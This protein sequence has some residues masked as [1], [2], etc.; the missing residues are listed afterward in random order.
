MSL[1]VDDAELPASPRVDGVLSGSVLQGADRCGW[2]LE[3]S[4][5]E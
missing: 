5:T 1:P 4:G 2:T 3:A